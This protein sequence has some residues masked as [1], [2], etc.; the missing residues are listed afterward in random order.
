[1]TGQELKLL[2]KGKG[3]NQEEAASLLGMSRQALNV[4]LGKGT[5]SSD[6]LKLAKERLES[7]IPELPKLIL[8]RTTN[9]KLIAAA[10]EMLQ[11]LQE[12]VKYL[13]SLES[14]D[15]SNMPF[16]W[17]DDFIGNLKKTIKKAT[18]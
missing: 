18:E 5:L 8:E 17:D 15:G 11:S 9:A 7:I 6:F 2:I 1:M 16:E 14:L 3:I 4:Q 12:C 13:S 10:P